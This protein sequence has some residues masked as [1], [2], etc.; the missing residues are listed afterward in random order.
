MRDGKGDTRV[1][2]FLSEQ[3]NL[4]QGRSESSCSGGFKAVEGFHVEDEGPS[5]FRTGDFQAQLLVLSTSA[6]WGAIAGCSRAACRI[7]LTPSETHL[8]SSILIMIPGIGIM[9]VPVEKQWLGVRV[10][11][12]RGSWH[13]HDLAVT[14]GTSTPFSRPKFLIHKSGCRISAPFPSRSCREGGMWWWK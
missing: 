8:A 13:H 9:L 3:I 11:P 4:C 6:A 2:R 7:C 1:H 14:L 12:S 5:G 10:G